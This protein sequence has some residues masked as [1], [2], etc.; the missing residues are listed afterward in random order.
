VSVDM[1]DPRDVVSARAVMQPITTAFVATVKA[2]VDDAGVDL[3]RFRAGERKD[4]IAQG[5]LEASDGTEQVLGRS[6]AR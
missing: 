4:D 5:Y 2:F 6:D 3:V 1:V